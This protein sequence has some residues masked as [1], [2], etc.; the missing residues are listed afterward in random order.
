MAAARSGE[1]QSHAPREAG[2]EEERAP[3]PPSVPPGGLVAEP[4]PE[5]RSFREQ[6]PFIWGWEW[7][8]YGI[9]DRLWGTPPLYTALEPKDR[10]LAE[11][12][13]DVTVCC[14]LESVMAGRFKLIVP[15][16]RWGGL[17]WE[18]LAGLRRRCCKPGR[19]RIMADA[20]VG[21]SG[22]IEVRG[23]HYRDTFTLDFALAHEVA[24]HLKRYVVPGRKALV[25]T[26][27]DGEGLRL[28]RFKEEV[29][30]PALEAVG[31]STELD[32]IDLTVC[33]EQEDGA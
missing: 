4:V 27:D 23:M 14:A 32:P 19:I 22:R 8:R 25:F 29:W 9:T 30:T 21:P 6:H 13:A 31:L 5:L 17:R 1:V 7:V 26:H 12:L 15:L 3:C 28:G 2:V 33:W 24:E 18:E 11:Q 10:P 20:D 16:M